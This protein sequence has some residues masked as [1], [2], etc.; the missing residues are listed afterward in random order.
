M[1]VW[2]HYFT[3]TAESTFITDLQMQMA[4]IKFAICLQNDFTLKQQQPFNLAFTK[5]M[6][7]CYYD[8]PEATRRIKNLDLFKSHLLWDGSLCLVGFCV[9]LEVRL[10]YMCW[11]VI[12]RGKTQE[13][14][15]TWVDTSVSG[16][17]KDVQ[18][19]VAGHWLWYHALRGVSPPQWPAPWPLRTLKST[20]SREKHTATVSWSKNET[21]K[22]E[23]IISQISSTSTFLSHLNTHTEEWQTSVC[24]IW[25]PCLS[26]SPVYSLAVP[27]GGHTE[28]PPGQ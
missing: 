27:P 28:T 24:V 4:F 7:N 12:Q 20:K 9:W 11:F 5:N 1:H 2:K 17:T 15:H 6:S 13:L 16:G 22:Q 18:H 8:P 26:Q 19:H 10:P 3:N 14:L 25:R 23:N 21:A